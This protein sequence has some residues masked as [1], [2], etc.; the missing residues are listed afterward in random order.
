MGDIC[1]MRKMQIGKSDVRD[2]SIVGLGAWAIG[3]KQWWG[4]NNDRESEDTIRAALD[5][6]INL[7]DTAPVYGFGHSEE[8]VGRAIAGMRDRV[9]LSTKCGL[10][11]DEREG[12]AFFKKEGKMIKRSLSS[13]SIRQDIEESLKRLGT[14]YIDIYLTHWQA[15]EPFFTPIEETMRTLTDLKKQGK[16]RAIGA[17]NLSPEQIEQYMDAGQLDIIQEKYSILDRRAEKKFFEICRKYGI[18]FQAYSPLEMGI[19]TGKISEDF[20][21]ASGSARDQKHWYQPENLRRAVRM[22]AGWED[23][24]Q[25]YNC[26]PTRLAIAW[27]LA[28]NDNINILC[29]ARKVFQVKDNAGGG[30]LIMEKEDILRMTKDA[31]ETGALV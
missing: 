16:I 22:V 27:L 7:I 15:E 2:V 5:L 8:V 9:I 30:D 23:L 14:D 24:A 19:L 25:K 31:Q 13:D 4:D 28:Q 18:T 3:G 1:A 11:W 21:P 20:T 17:S 6:G 29:G 12:T 10:I 26:T